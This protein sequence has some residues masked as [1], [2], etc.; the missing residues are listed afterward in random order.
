ML[1]L[2]LAAILGMQAP[3]P[4]PIVCNMTRGTPYVAHQTEKTYTLNLNVDC[5]RGFMIWTV[6]PFNGMGEK[7][8]V[9]TDTPRRGPITVTVTRWDYRTRSIKIIALP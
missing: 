4:S 1:S 8:L 2:I 9:W 7:Q 5:N 6:S 3:A